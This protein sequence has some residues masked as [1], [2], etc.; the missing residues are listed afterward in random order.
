MPTLYTD[1]DE[2][3]YSDVLNRVLG[4]DD[5]MITNHY[6]NINKVNALMDTGLPKELCEK[7]VKMSNTLRPCNFCNTKLCD[8]HYDRGTY[9]LKYYKGVNGGSMCDQC[10]WWEVT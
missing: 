4:E 7:I 3:N 5:S 8:F 6:N 10:C 2:C 9:Y 1:C